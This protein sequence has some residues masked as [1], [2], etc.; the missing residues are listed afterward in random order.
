M[1]R[2]QLMLGI[3]LLA[4]STA[5]TALSWGRLRGT[6]LM[7]RGLDVSIQLIT[8]AQ[9]KLPEASCFAADVFYGE[10]RVSSQG[11][12]IS[13][14]TTASGES[15]IRIRSNTPVDEP[16]VTLFLSTTCGVNISRRFVLL[17][18]ML[19]PQ[20][21]V[22]APV[23]PLPSAA[24]APTRTAATPLAPSA[25]L[26]D[27]SPARPAASGLTTEPRPAVPRSARARPVET[28][29]SPAGS[30][31]PDAAA[32]RP[33]SPPRAQARASDR[34]AQK[35]K[36]RLQLDLLD[37]G[38][39]EPSLRNSWELASEP[40]ADAAVRAQA[41][42]LWRSLNAS[43]EDILQQGKRLDALEAQMRQSLERSSKQDAQ[44]A[45]LSS[46][47]E[48]SQKARYLNPFTVFLGLLTL[49]A[50]ALCVW[51][52]RRGASQDRPWWRGEVEAQPQQ[53][54]EK[55][56]KHLDEDLM[57]DVDLGFEDSLNQDKS[58][59]ARLAKAEQALAGLHAGSSDAVALNPLGSASPA[60]AAESPAAA[61]AKAPS[62]AM[63]RFEQTKPPAAQP[64]AR[65]ASRVPS[66]PDRNMGY[67]D[68]ANSNFASSRLVSTEELF[69]I[70]EQADFFMS[71]DQPE[72]AIAVLK[73]HITDNVETSAL[74]YMDLFDIYRRT[75]REN[76]YDQLR[77]E[78]NRVFNAEVPE[79]AN[80]SELSMGLEEY[81][82]AMAT[83]VQSWPKPQEAQGVIEEYIFRQPDPQQQPF[84]MLAYRELML[85]YAMT[86]DLVKT[87]SAENMLPTIALLKQ[88]ISGDAVADRGLDISL[89]LESPAE[90]SA[91]ASASPDVE[92]PAWLKELD[93]LAAPEPQASAKAEPE[94]QPPPS[95]PPLDF[96]LSNLNTPS[97]PGSGRAG[98]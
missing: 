63:A 4:A 8:D 92:E 76:E 42:A 77:E 41:L 73:N 28:A 85:L 61:P 3:T 64:S 31:T 78:F 56:W 30:R 46:E 20:E 22:L 72:Q 93:Q 50:L 67:S 48:A 2:W 51:L 59:K 25:G 74:A 21:P 29:E 43:P 75:G 57:Q 32:K 36:P 58:S 16:V 6:P 65:P 62:G 35:S 71:L 98:G 11:I 38:S 10:T 13:P 55:L 14:E 88:A 12:S 84:D 26:A 39:S 87:Q 97:K 66:L 79:F 18:E 27:A 15:R 19:T 54:E 53:S 7:G 34:P 90:A 33:S 80:Y 47:L 82:Q 60:R 17:A 86:K 9:E 89:D 24:T 5:A 69:D 37:L 70:Q 95:L 45:A 91:A 68:F 96:D 94:V 83:I 44:I 1:K 23:L 52:W 49:V 81:P 40:T